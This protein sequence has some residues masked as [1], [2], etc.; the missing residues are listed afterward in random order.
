MGTGFF[1]AFTGDRNEVQSN[2]FVQRDLI[3][4]LSCPCFYRN[5]DRRGVGTGGVLF[6]AR[7]VVPCIPSSRLTIVK[8]GLPRRVRRGKERVEAFVPG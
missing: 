6:I 1:C 3:L 4:V 8:E 5:G 2:I 7:R